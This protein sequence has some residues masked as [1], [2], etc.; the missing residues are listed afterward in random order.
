[1]TENSKITLVTTHLE[2]LSRPEREIGP[3][4][5]G[6]EV[7][8][9]ENPPIHFYRYLYD[10]I[11]AP[12]VWWER[13]R[14]SDAEIAAE[15][16][17]P[18]FR[19]YVPYLNHVPIGMVELDCRRFPDVQLN[20]FGI[21]PEYCGQGLGSYV[22][23]WSVDLVWNAGA[24]RYWLHTCSLDSPAALPVYCKAGFAEFKTVTEEVDDP[25]QG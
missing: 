12:W 7:R 1:M 4:P 25:S 21:I 3:A 6:L 14:Q 16:H 24:T 22:L 18:E 2:M 20:Y 23:N 8:R 19:F 17:S 5:A 10:T 13:K 15:L 9:V 11:G